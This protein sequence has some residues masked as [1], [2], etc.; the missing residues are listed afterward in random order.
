MNLSDLT[1]GVEIET[2]T[3]AGL[4]RQ[5]V[6]EAAAA[7]LGWT[8]SWQP[9]RYGREETILQ[10]GRSTPWVL[11]HDGSIRTPENSQ[12]CEVISPVLRYPEDLET[13]ESVVRVVKTLATVNE[14]CGLHVHVG[15][16]D[17]SGPALGRLAALWAAKEDLIYLAASTLA[18]R[19]YYCHKIGPAIQ[20]ADFRPTYHGDAIQQ[21]D[22]VSNRYAGLNIGPALEAHR[23]VEF[24]LWNSTLHAGKIKAAV[25]FSL[26]LVARA[27]NIS[28]AT[29][30]SVRV[31]EGAT[32]AAFRTF[33]RALGLDGPEFA[34]LRHHLLKPLEGWS[35]WSSG[36]PPADWCQRHG[37][38]GSGRAGRAPTGWAA[39]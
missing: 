5:Q 18:E 9:V 25:Q 26:A 39:V 2:A 19:Q 22:R 1:F 37:R 6:A 38:D 8:A 31:Q 21:W 34:T 35:A 10:P 7:R 13:L 29:N 17:L 30:R 15:A 16:Q 4:S 23:T 36:K 27:A 20:R 12:K 24:R 32:K 11:R 14:S 3:C 33:L 28:R